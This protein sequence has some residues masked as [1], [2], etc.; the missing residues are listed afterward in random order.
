MDSRRSILSKRDG[1]R[2]GFEVVQRRAEALWPTIASELG[3]SPTGTK[4]GR[5]QVNRKT[6]DHCCV[7]R[8]SLEDG[9]EFVL[10]ADFG[11]GS[12]HQHQAIISRH[13]VA[14]KSL[15]FSPH[16]SVP[17]L[18]WWDTEHKYSLME[19]APGE[20]AFQA[21]QMAGLGFGDRRQLVERMG[22]AVRVLHQCSSADKQR[23]WP[24]RHLDAVSQTAEAVREGHLTVLK[25]KRFL[26]LCAYLHRSARRSKGI[27]FQPGFTHGDLHFRNVLVSADQISFIDFSSRGFSIVERDIS[28]LWLANGLDHLSG[29]DGD[30]GFGGVSNSDW[31]AFEAGYGRKITHEPLFQF[32]FAL[33]LWESWVRFSISGRAA[34]EKGRMQLKL[35]VHVV[36][37][38]LAE[39]V[40]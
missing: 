9:S 26:G 33:R 2:Y 36:D 12:L 10:R 27:R 31:A 37:L 23:F 13:Q 24:K 21:L 6:E 17:Q 30:T 16:A 20:T 18:L 34:G 25:P 8:V 5:M 1:R 11:E 3:L 19:F 14:A 7:L 32:C 15:K 4:F 22:N 38:L 40:G 29:I 35:L 39:E 28:N